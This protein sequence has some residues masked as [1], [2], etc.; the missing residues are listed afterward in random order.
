MYIGVL[1]VLGLLGLLAVA[2]HRE[3]SRRCHTAVLLTG[4]SYAFLFLV[5]NVTWLAENDPLSG[6]FLWYVPLALVPVSLSLAR[7]RPV[8]LAVLVPSV[9]ASSTGR[10]I[11]WA[12]KALDHVLGRCSGPQHSPGLFLDIGLS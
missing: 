11:V 6:R 8:L 12:S 7:N 10:N 4:L 3:L 9:L 1:F 5:F 2:R